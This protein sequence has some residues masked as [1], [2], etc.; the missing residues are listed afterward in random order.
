MTALAQRQPQKGTENKQSGCLLGCWLKQLDDDSAFYE[1]GKICGEIVGSVWGMPW[2][3]C[4]LNIPVS[5]GTGSP[6]LKRE[7]CLETQ[8]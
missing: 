2:R 1:T 8:K 7:T 4:L 3:T 5:S 6:E